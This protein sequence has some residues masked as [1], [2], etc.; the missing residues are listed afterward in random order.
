[1]RPGPDDL[2][3]HLLVDGRPVAALAVATGRL[4]RTRGLLGRDH[5]DG[6]L[7]LPATSSVH[8]FAMRFAVDVALCTRDLTVVAVRTVG[9]GRLV[10]PRW[11][12]RAVLEA[13]AGAFARW[14]LGPGSRL[15]VDGA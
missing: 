8:T 2:V 15:D 10:L 1:M 6:A 3:C 4:A 11:Q 5:L 13:E 9:P 12:V 7:L 14:G